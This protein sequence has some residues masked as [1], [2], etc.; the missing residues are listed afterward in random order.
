MGRFGGGD[1][2]KG[3]KI[4]RREGVEEGKRGRRVEKEW[5]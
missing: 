3:I 1:R 4:E 5:E 2:K